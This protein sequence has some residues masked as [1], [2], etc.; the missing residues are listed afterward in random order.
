M[1]ALTLHKLWTNIALRYNHAISRRTTATRLCTYESLSLPLAAR[2]PI[3]PRRRQPEYPENF[4]TTVALHR[5]S[6]CKQSLDHCCATPRLYRE[7]SMNY[8]H[9]T[10]VRITNAPAAFPFDI[11]SSSIIH[12]PPSGS[13]MHHSE[14][15]CPR[16]F[17]TELSPQN[18]L[19]EVH[20]KRS[21]HRA[22][23]PEL[24]GGGP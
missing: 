2:I 5:D 4:R 16:T 13:K 3:R 1:W 7:E 11:D 14:Q 22:L 19:E 9:V 20:K 21:L 18:S 6:L 23:F 10:M 12:D 17:F 8:H 15:K 24:P